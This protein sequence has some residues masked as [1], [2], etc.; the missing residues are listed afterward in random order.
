[1]YGS[2]AVGLGAELCRHIEASLG[3]L[4]S[5]ERGRLVASYWER[6]LSDPRTVVAEML[7][8]LEDIGLGPAH[9]GHLVDALI[10]LG[11]DV[12]DPWSASSYLRKI[13]SEPALSETLVGR[14]LS[15]CLP[16]VC[17]RRRPGDYRPYEIPSWGAGVADDGLLVLRRRFETVKAEAFARIAEPRHFSEVSAS[18]SAGLTAFLREALRESLIGGMEGIGR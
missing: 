8:R 4:V 14:D 18:V 2:D 5:G 1:M 3:R 16:Y 7:A 9:S 10:G 13:M 17:Y 12:T 11:V 15:G 6:L